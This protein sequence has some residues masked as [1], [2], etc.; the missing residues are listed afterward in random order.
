M[1]W[2]TKACVSYADIS[3]EKGSRLPPFLTHSNYLSV[4]D[5]KQHDDRDDGTDQQQGAR[6]DRGM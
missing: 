1:G 6:F 4:R 3:I 2:I 5:F